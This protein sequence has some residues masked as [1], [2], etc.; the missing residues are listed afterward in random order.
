M[1]FCRKYSVHCYPT[2]RLGDAVLPFVN[3]TKFHGLVFDRA[4]TWRQ[5]I[6]SL[7]T[8]CN[9]ALNVLRMLIRTSWGADRVTLLWLHRA[10]VRSILGYGTIVYGYASTTNLRALDTVHH[11]ASVW[12]LV[13]FVLAIFTAYLSMLGNLL[14]PCVETYFFAATVLRYLAF[15]T[16]QRIGLFCT[17]NI[18]LPMLIG[19]PFLDLQVSV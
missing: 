5:H 19:C 11:A 12:R 2:L 7:R 18:I 9:C 10:L 8:R 4:L 16:T 3:S 6:C 13:H 15:Q 17:P 14:F 1:H